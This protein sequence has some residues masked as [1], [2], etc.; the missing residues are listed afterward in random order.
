MVSPPIA[1][2]FLEANWLPE[3]D[4]EARQIILE[5]LEEHQAPA[6]AVLLDESR[7]ND[8]VFF[9]IDGQ[10]LISRSRPGAHA[11]AIVEINAPSL[12]GLTT[13]F[14]NAAPDFS[15]RT[16]TP[17][18]YLTL[19]REAHR[20]LRQNHPAAAEQLALAAIHVLSDR[21]AMLD[22]RITAE[23]NQHPDTQRATEWSRFRARLFD[24]SLL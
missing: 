19:T 1:R 21:I 18:T 20:R 13:F 16:L 15:A 7:P 17:V 5:S 8:L 3:M 6:D 14:R 22:H 12:F 11:E 24:E 10:V 23:L 9:L 4:A 2:R